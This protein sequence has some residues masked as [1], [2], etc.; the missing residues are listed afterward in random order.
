[1]AKY[2]IGKE[3]KDLV[4]KASGKGFKKFNVKDE[5]GV[6]TSDVIAFGNYSQ[7][8][9]ITPGAT[10]EA[11]LSE[12][13][14]NG[15]KDYKL[16]DGN[17]GAKP[18]GFGGG[19]AKTMEKKA[20]YIEKA[21]GRKADS[22]QEAATARDATLILT[23]YFKNGVELPAEVDDRVMKA[24]EVKV[25]NMWRRIRAWLMDNWEVRESLPDGSLMPTFEPPVGYP[26][27]FKSI[28]EEVVNFP[29]D[30]EEIPFS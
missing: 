7:Y 20:E 12:G 10:V 2:Q 6:V 27:S 11:V 17:L 21:Q 16:V 1:M 18:A 26:D 14:Y 15:K 13:E 29:S 25:M 28:N 3:V 24:H 23:S 22:I 4:G 5:K 19:M 9:Q 8:A 30:E